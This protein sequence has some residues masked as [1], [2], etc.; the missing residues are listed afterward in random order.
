RRGRG[1]PGP[2][3]LGAGR[4]QG[5]ARGAGG[6]GPAR[7]RARG[8][9]AGAAPGRHAAAWLE[10]FAEG[11][12]GSGG[13][14]GCEGPLPGGLPAGAG[15]GAR[16]KVAR[17]EGTDQWTQTAVLSSSRNCAA[18]LLEVLAHDRGF[19]AAAARRAFLG[20]LAA[21]AAAGGREADLAR[22]LALVGGAGAERAL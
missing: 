6:Q 8:A 2:R 5:A 16:A 9:R 20:R 1:G 7:R 10:D 22:A 12:R 21:V 14:R 15:G 13:R 19:A 4:A 3:P 11:C 17:H 18:E